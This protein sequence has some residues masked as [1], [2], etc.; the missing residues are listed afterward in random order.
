MSDSPD[1]KTLAEVLARAFA[2]YLA[3]ALADE[4]GAGKV[5]DYIDQHA[6]PLGA[7]RHCRLIRDGVIAGMQAGRRW[8]AKREDVD[9]YI[10]ERSKRKRKKPSDDAAELAEELGLRLVGGSR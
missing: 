9:A 1:L 10:A 4:L 7:R 8:L 3:R 6:S 2:P 5:G